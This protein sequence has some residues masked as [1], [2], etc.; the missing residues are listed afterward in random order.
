M[1]LSLL[2]LSFILFLLFFFLPSSS[3]SPFI[4]LITFSTGTQFPSERQ[5]HSSVDVHV[6]ATDLSRITGNTFIGQQNITKSS[7]YV[8]DVMIR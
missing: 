3:S 6:D 5:G 4:H 7:R 2:P 1:L 8:F